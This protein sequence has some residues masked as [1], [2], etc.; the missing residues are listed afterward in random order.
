MTAIYIDKYGVKHIA[1]YSLNH[2]TIKNRRKDDCSSEKEHKYESSKKKCNGTF[3]RNAGG[4][5]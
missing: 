2:C 5:A 4:A 1:P 3:R